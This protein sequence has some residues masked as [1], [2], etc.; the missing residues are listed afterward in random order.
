MSF[1]GNEGHQYLCVFV[2]FKGFSFRKQLFLCHTQP[3]LCFV[4]LDTE[5]NIE[6]LICTEIGKFV[7]P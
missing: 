2:S 5:K 6:H 1:Y 4:T 7:C 3:P